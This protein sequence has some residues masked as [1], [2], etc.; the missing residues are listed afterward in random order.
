VECWVLRFKVSFIQ[1]PK[2][3]SSKAKC[4]RLAG[5]LHSTLQVQMDTHKPGAMLGGWEPLQPLG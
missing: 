5:A 3:A 4:T 1:S 2:P